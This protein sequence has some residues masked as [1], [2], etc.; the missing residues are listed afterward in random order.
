M[1]EKKNSSTGTK[2]LMDEKNRFEYAFM[3]LGPSITS[4]RE[5]C[6]L[7]IVIDGTHLKGSFEVLCSSL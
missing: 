7:L 6:R 1:L 4:F 3:S 2:L 5:Y